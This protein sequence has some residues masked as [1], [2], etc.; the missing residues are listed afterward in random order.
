MSYPTY[1]QVKRLA[2]GFAEGKNIRDRRRD[3]NDLVGLLNNSDV[4]QRLGAEAN[5]RPQG[6][7]EMWR[8]LVGHVLAG[9]QDM[10]SSGKKSKLLPEDVRTLN[11]I[12]EACVRAQEGF[13]NELSSSKLTKKEVRSAVQFSLELLD[14]VDDGKL[15]IDFEA[16]LLETL[17][18]LCSC[19]EFVVHCRPENDTRAILEVAERRI[20]Q[21][22]PKTIIQ[23]AQIFYRLLTASASMQISL[24]SLLPG[25]VK[26]VAVWCRSKHDMS[27]QAIGELEYMIEGVV[28]L[29]N[30]NPEQA[31]GPLTRHGAVILKFCKRRY[32]KHAIRQ[33]HKERDALNHYFVAHM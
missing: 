20:E 29:L 16:A 8:L 1:N 4:R 28:V 27:E 5:W 32:G 7:R 2:Q 19:K 22:K 31:I 10:H 12:L 14:E 15:G 26:M 24:D 11:K 17:N 13:E 3:G 21:D 30:S 18:Q 25:C 23:A 33:N 9:L 6:L